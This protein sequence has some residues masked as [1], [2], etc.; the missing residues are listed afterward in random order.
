MTARAFPEIVAL[1]I[2]EFWFPDDEP[3]PASLGV[4]V[5][6]AIRRGECVLAAPG[7]ADA[8]RPRRGILRLPC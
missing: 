6:N 4:V 3:W 8:C 2:S 5:A 1:D 7:R